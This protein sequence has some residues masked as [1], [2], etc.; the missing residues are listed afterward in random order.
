VIAG[1]NVVRLTDVLVGE[2]WICSGQSNMEYPLNRTRMRGTAPP[3]ENVVDLA[4]REIRR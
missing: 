3:P 4:T 1:T 2:V